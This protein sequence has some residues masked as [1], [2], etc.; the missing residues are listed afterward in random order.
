ME[1]KAVV[2]KPSTQDL[3]EMTTAELEEY[4]AAINDSTQLRKV[5][6]VVKFR[7]EALKRLDQG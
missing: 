3:V 5:M 2:R 1:T 6:L 7:L 4:A